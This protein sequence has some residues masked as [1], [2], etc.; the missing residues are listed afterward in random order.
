[1]W[2][3][4]RTHI[5]DAQMI[6]KRSVL[7]IKKIFHTV[8][9]LFGIS[10]VFVCV[11]SG[12][13]KGKNSQHRCFSSRVDRVRSFFRLSCC[14]ECFCFIFFFSSS[15][16]CFVVWHKRNSM[17]LKIYLKFVFNCSQRSL[18]EL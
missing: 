4:K 14:C 12:K 15:F 1:M 3:K 8:Q 2:K 9:Y 17:D 11:E 13:G 18:V 6:G 10:D 7:C 16:G 5:G